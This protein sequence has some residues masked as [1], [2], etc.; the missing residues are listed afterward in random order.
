MVAGNRS[1]EYSNSKKLFE[2]Y[3][4]STRVLATALEY[5]RLPAIYRISAESAPRLPVPHTQ[6]SN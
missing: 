2:Y 6:S 5:R 4:S 1:L 3:Y